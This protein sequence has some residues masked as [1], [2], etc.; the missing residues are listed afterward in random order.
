LKNIEDLPPLPDQMEEDSV[1]E[2]ADL[3]FGRFEDL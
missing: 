1:Q 3:F 2:E